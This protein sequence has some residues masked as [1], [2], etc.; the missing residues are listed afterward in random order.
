MKKLAV[1][2]SA[3]ALTLCGV[4]AAQSV[5]GFDY[6]AAPAASG[7]QG[8]ANDAP[9]TVKGVLDNGY[10]DQHVVLVGRLTNY[11]GHD[12]YE[13]TDKTGRIEVELDD[14][15]N[16]SHISKDQLI[17]IFGKIDKDLMSTTIDVKQATP[18]AQP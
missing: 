5:N 12:R 18:V 9:N 15:K 11:L 4:A 2:V 14:D 10:D 1:L 13:F 17:Q 16:W 6:S 3:V 8:F 7:P